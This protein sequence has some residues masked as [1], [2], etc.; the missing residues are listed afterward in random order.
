VPLLFSVVALLLVALTVQI[1]RA[2]RQ[3]GVVRIEIAA[4]PGESCGTL[5]GQLVGAPPLARLDRVRFRLAL[6]VPDDS[7]DSDNASGPTTLWERRFDAPVDELRMARG[8]RE[9][10]IPFSF[11]E[12]PD[13]DDF[14]LGDSDYDPYWCLEVRGSGG[15]PPLAA[16]WLLNDRDDGNI[17]TPR[18]RV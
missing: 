8:D 1:R 3:Y 7:S 16:S 4:Y 10:R 18:S 13:E 6:Q 9:C 12:V 14:P 2:G 11:D 5:R 17:F 15:G